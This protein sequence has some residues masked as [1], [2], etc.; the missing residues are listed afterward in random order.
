V[1]PEPSPDQIG[2]GNTVEPEPLQ[3]VLLQRYPLR[4]GVRAS[5]HYES[6]F[7]EFALLA[8]VEPGPSVPTRMLA[9]IDEL[10]RRYSRDN[11]TEQQRDSALARGEETVDIELKLPASAG[12][13]GRRLAR[14]LDETDEFCRQGQL[15]TL[16]PAEDVVHF[17]QWYIDE[18]A[19]QLDGEE[20]HPWPG[21]VS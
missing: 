3:P 15:L 18:L 6:V 16:A 9:L 2:D 5:E 19:R 20:P 8:T 17:R 4:L 13:A 10:G 12:A 1:T 21:E 14:L 7:R 11:A